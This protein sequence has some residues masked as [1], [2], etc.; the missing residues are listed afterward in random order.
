[1]INKKKLSGNLFIIYL[2]LIVLFCSTGLAVQPTDIVGHWAEDNISQW[3]DKGL[4]T[5]YSDGSFKPN[6]SITRA[7]FM[8]LVNRA[9]GFAGQASVSFSDVNASNWFY[10]DAAKAVAA[11]YM[12]GYN[13]GT[14]RP[15]NDISR[16]E[17]AV[18]LSRLLKMPQVSNM[19]VIQNFS[20]YSS[21][22]AWSKEAVNSVVVDAY[23]G[24]YPDGSYGPANSITR[25]ETVT[26][27][28]RAIGQLYNAPGTFGPEQGIQT[29]SGN[30]TVNT[31]DVELQ[32][33]T[34]EGNLYLT[35]GIGDGDVVL[36]NVTVKGTTVISGGGENSITL[37]DCS[38]NEVIVERVDGKVRIIA[39]GNTN[40]QI[41]RV[42]SGTIID[43]SALTDDGTDLITIYVTTDEEV[44]LIG[45]FGTVYI[46]NEGSKVSILSGTIEKLI[47]AETATNSTVFVAENATIE[48][49]EINTLITVTGQGTIEL[50]IIGEGAG[51][52]TFENEP[53]TIE[54][55]Q[56]TVEEPS[57]GGGGG[58][59]GGGYSEADA[60]AALAAL[61]KSEV[62]ESNETYITTFANNTIT[63]TILNQAADI[64]SL[65]GSGAMVSLADMDE[66]RGYEIGGETR[67]F[68]NGT[69]REDNLEIKLWLIT[70]AL[71]AL[72]LSNIA[73]GDIILGDLVNKSFSV[74]VNG[75]VYGINFTDTYTFEFE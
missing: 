23:M 30:V 19:T 29:I 21:I 53:E 3:V 45:N 38:L 47:I 52:S 9:Y 43:T 13:D 67:D 35:A 58:G 12:A 48:T 66:V 20:D 2:F 50:A 4:I 55:E 69:I 34:I 72:G 42:E 14:L 68:Y 11:G 46:E 75:L 65:Y 28:A 17:V 7:E 31:A 1:M 16:Q 40:I 60:K 71:I 74:E 57:A 18:I 33:I 61:V 39:N 59:G 62:E 41:I 24:G 32:N 49:M 63:I 51:E 26:V 56:P 54:G 36:T 22:P 6:E 5:G 70:D 44:E 64:L 10:D 37:E 25:A 8:A 73:L 15:N 27:L